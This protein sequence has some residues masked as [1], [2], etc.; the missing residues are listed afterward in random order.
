M[1]GW[2][3]A[4]ASLLALCGAVSSSHAQTAWPAGSAENEGW[5]LEFGARAVFSGGRLQKNLYDPEV[6]SQLN[7]RLTYGGAAA[8]SAELFGRID[9][10][11]GWFVKGYVGVGRQNGGTLVDEDYP[12]AEMPYSRTYSAMREGRIDYGSIDVGHVLW[13]SPSMRIAGFAGVHHFRESYNGFGCLQVAPGGANCQPTI[14]GSVLGLSE[15]AR[16]TSL[17][18]GIVGDFA[19]TERLTLTAEAVFL[20]YARLNTVDKHWLQPDMGPMA[21]NGQG[22]GAQIEASL[23]YRLTEHVSIGGGARFWYLATTG[24]KTLFAGETNASPMSFR[25]E[26]WGA[27]VQA[28]YRL[29]F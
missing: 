5:R 10:P 26:R 9:A 19:L 13:R 16:W 11:T 15:A 14:P 6:P 22:F 12:P 24:A 20:P 7:S 2:R 23:S 1:I 3:T 17:R 29:P 8:G 28:S 25:S 21:E 18:L 4:A 27:F